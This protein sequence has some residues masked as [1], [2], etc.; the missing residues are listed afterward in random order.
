MRTLVVNPFGIGD[1][2][3]S[4]P[5]LHALRDRDPDGFL[6]LLCNRRTEELAA[7]WS[8]LDW[9][10]VFEKD[11]FRWAW[12][13][14]KREGIQTLA[15]IVRQVR[16]E[17]FDLLVDLSMGW[18]I[19]LAALLAGIPRRVGFDFRGRGR[20]LTDRLPVNGFH[21]Q[22]VAEYY[23]D[24]LQLLE[25]PRPSSPRLEL[26]LPAGTDSQVE[27]YLRS[28]KIPPDD[29]LIGMV[30]GGGASWGPHAVFKQWPPERFA[31]VADDLSHRY[32]ARI[33]LI[34]DSEEAPL[35]R[36]V[37]STMTSPAGL[38]IQVPSL[39]L[40]AGLLKR[41]ELVVGNDS[42]PM[43]IAAA[44]GAKTVSIFGPVDGSIYG[45]FPAGPIHRVV[46]KGLACRP[47]YQG[48]RFPPCPWDNACLK[49]LEAAE[50][51]RAAG[52]LLR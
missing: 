31:R 39:M 1:V 12:R 52:E 2:L 25:L 5:L 28:L 16:G 11:E 44:V 15:R 47:C 38:A 50:V 24:L 6:G 46:A 49:Q 37:T 51:T 22:P 36:E 42:G 14:S 48:F 30:P 29:R 32:G 9:R 43:H 17:R 8:F 23:L 26:E 7:G 34:G 21:D 35:C 41:C 45:P 3:F 40:L 13:R 18:Q 4:L 27:A 20:F 10:S 33:L 19:G